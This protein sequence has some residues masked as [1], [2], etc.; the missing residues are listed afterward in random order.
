MVGAKMCLASFS[1][2]FKTPHAYEYELVRGSHQQRNPPPQTAEVG[3]GAGAQ[4][5][6][7][8]MCYIK[9]GTNKI[10]VVLWLGGPLR[11]D[12]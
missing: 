11:L 12:P 4:T 5:T 10:A 2:E 7:T 8:L 9:V 3:E 1:Q 6:L